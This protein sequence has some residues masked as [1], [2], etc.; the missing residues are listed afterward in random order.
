MTT[1]LF[2]VKWIIAGA[3]IASSYAFCISLPMAAV[4]GHRGLS[5]QGPGAAKLVFAGN[6][7]G[8]W[9]S[10]AAVFTLIYAAFVSL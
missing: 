8:A 9:L 5:A 3:F 1:S 4:V 7:A 6:V 2:I 10:A